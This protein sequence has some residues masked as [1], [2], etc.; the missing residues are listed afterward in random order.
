MTI[1]WPKHINNERQ[2]WNRKKHVQLSNI[3]ERERKNES[4]LYF[5]ISLSSFSIN[6][7][8]LLTKNTVQ[9]TTVTVCTYVCYIDPVR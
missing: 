7:V 1:S 3:I 4:I 9:S 2:L 5:A 8:S 6:S